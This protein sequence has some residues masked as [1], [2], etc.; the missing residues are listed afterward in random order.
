[1][2]VVKRHGWRRFRPRLMTNSYVYSDAAVYGRGTALEKALRLAEIYTQ[3]NPTIEQAVDQLK[4]KV[5]LATSPVRLLALALLL[6]PQASRAQAMM[7][8]HKNNFHDRKSR[9][10]ELIDFN[11]AFVAAVLS[12]DKSEEA[13]FAEHFRAAQKT[14]A[15]KH[16]TPLFTEG[17]WSAI[18]HGLSRETAV[19][20]A[21]QNAGFDV[22]MTTRTDD[23]FGVDM[24]IRERGNGAYINVDCKTHSS[25]FFRLK[26]LVRQ[27]RLTQDEAIKA[28]ET[29]YC[30]IENCRDYSCARVVL[31]RIDHTMLGDIVDF[32]F[33]DEVKTAQLLHEVVAKFGTRDQ[34]YGRD[35][36]PL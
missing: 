19:Y 17:Q 15:K 26:E 36:A 18:V 16:K 6:T 23:A 28:Q 34:G 35:I 25:F 22:I 7:D 3:Q 9:L 11:D 1:M 33:A 21:A 2:P 24:Q 4:T 31:L 10:F 30:L 20:F 5:S 12:L 13:G 14:Y 29:G 32:R 8:A 27:K